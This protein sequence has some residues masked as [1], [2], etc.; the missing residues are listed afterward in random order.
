[1][2]RAFVRV[3]G[4]PPQAVRRQARREAQVLRKHSS[5]LVARAS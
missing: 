4:L 2:R 5:E 1:M 3:F